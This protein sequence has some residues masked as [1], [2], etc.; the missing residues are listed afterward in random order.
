MLYSVPSDVEIPQ[1]SFVLH[2]L[3]IFEDYKQFYFVEIAFIYGL[4]GVSLWFGMCAFG[5]H[6]TV[7]WCVLLSTS[8]QVMGSFP[9]LV[10]LTNLDHLVKVVPATFLYHDVTIL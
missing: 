5:G 3:D 6:I 9:V 7:W 4:A 10:L 2:N 1:I 8:Y